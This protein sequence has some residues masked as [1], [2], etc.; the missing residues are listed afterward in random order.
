MYHTHTRAHTPE[1]MQG[2][3]DWSRFQSGCICVL[4]ER[5]CLY[6]ELEPC[7]ASTAVFLKDQI[8]RFEEKE[9][10]LFSMYIFFLVKK[11]NKKESWKKKV[12]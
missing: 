8:C 10:K 7:W 1:D 4:S 12:T 6:L 3:V 11:I 9:K 2:V 5:V